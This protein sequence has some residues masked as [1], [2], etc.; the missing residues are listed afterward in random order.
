MAEA[1][2][3]CDQLSKR[4][5]RS[6]AVRDASIA[7]EAGAVYGLVGRNGAGK[8]TLI[9]MLLGLTRPTAGCARVLGFDP[10]RDGVEIRRRVG[11]VPETH[12]MYPWMTLR[13]LLAFVAPFYPTWDDAEAHRLLH[14]FGLDENKPIR[15]LSRGMVAKTAL[16]LALAHHPEVLVLDEPTGGLDAVIRSEFLE[17]ITDMA[18]SSGKTV[19]VSSHLLTDVERIVDTIILI[20]EGR[21]RVV[22]SLE[23][24]KDRVREVRVSFADT[25]PD[26]FALPGALTLDREGRE[27][28]A[29]VEDFDAHAPERYRALSPPGAAFA[30]RRLTLEEIFVALV[31]GGDSDR[32]GEG[33]LP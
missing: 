13:Q 8:T 26:A 32:H 16:T 33:T 7:L 17:S 10:V 12:A 21:I 30:C 20:E 24:L 14:H 31:K 4:Y 3:W 15:E 9:R 29:V 19:L 28:V 27:W 11:Y 5:G 1:A 23:N 22:D 25:T 18:S 6:M 2:I